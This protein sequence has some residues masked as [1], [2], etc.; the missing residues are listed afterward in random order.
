M[1]NDQ[2]HDTRARFGRRFSA[3]DREIPRPPVFPP[4]SAHR[5]APRLAAIGA[6][7]VAAVALVLVVVSSLAPYFATN[8]PIAGSSPS[9]TPSGTAPSPDPTP[10]GGGTFP[11][12]LT[13]ICGHFPGGPGPT[14]NPSLTCASAVHVALAVV[15][16]VNPRYAYF[17]YGGYCPPSARCA[18]VA[19]RGE[20]A[21][22][23]FHWTQDEPDIVVHVSVDDSGQLIPILWPR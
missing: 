12:G 15:P 23:V 10:A 17:A 22:I 20:L 5:P 16:T 1:L 2:D 11:A 7:T 8:P 21:H 4:V 19:N 18:W 13:V 9:A 6:V 3:I 14:P